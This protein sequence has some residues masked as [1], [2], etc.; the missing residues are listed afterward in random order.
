MLHTIHSISWLW[1]SYFHIKVWVS[2]EAV[3]AFVTE[4]N[5]LCG[6]CT[7]CNSPIVQWAMRHHQSSSFSL[8]LSSR[9]S[10]SVE[11]SS[12]PNVHLPNTPL[13]VLL[14]SPLNSS[15]NSALVPVLRPLHCHPL[16]VWVIYCYTMIALMCPLLYK[17]LWIKVSAKWLNVDVVQSSIVLHQIMYIHWFYH[18][19]C[20]TL[21]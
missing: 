21:F 8:S 9:S 2:A 19:G 3:D 20:S 4:Y 14:L 13:S 6:I 10:N 11:S 17:W 18:N 16:V 7:V 5:L 12:S 15:V 1:L